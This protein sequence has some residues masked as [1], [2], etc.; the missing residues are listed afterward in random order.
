MT[1]FRMAGYRGGPGGILSPGDCLLVP[2]TFST[3]ATVGAATIPGSAMV[4][5]VLYRTGSTAGY[6][7]TFDTAA[8]VMAAI[9]ANFASGPDIDAGIGF[10]LRLMNTVAFTETITLGAG[11]VAGLGT[12]SSVSASTWRDFLFSFS[13]TQV[14]VSNICSTT[15]GSNVVTWV[16]GVGQGSELQ[17]PSPLAVNV[18]PGATCIG[19]GIPNNTTVL[20]VTA[21]QGG[22]V[23]VTLSANATATSAAVMLSFGPAITVSSEGSGTL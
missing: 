2:D 6:T 9:S 16:L 4:S 14:P 1:A 21:G 11:M 15:S 19:T 7:D 23:G 22:T 5:G 10:K 20:G 18:Q 8:N 17:G 12:V 13:S 3:L